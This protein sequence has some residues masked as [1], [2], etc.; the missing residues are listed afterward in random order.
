MNVSKLKKTSGFTLI[1]VLVGAGLL[2][3]MVAFI[4]YLLISSLRAQ[5]FERSVRT[6]TVA[7][8]EAMNRMA[9][10]LRL[11]VALPAVG[12]TGV[13][14]M[15]ANTLPSGVLLP[16]S[17]GTDVGT[18]YTNNGGEYAV[19]KTKGTNGKCS[20]ANHLIFTR[21]K[22]GISMSNAT[23][24][25]YQF[26]PSQ[27]S[28]YVYVEWMVPQSTPDRLWR[29]VYTIKDGAT[30]NDIG[31]SA[32]TQD[33]INIG[34]GRSVQGVIW[35][36][37]T[38]FFTTEHIFYPAGSKQNDESN[39]LVCALNSETDSSHFSNGELKDKSRGE[40]FVR[41]KATMEF[42]VSH[43]IILNSYG[44]DIDSLYYT[45]YNRN[46]F[47]IAFKTTV[48]KGKD[49]GIAGGATEIKFETQV[50]LQAGT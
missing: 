27:L 35:V 5:E 26:N 29:R 40:T 48:H 25:S 4:A 16:D 7:T 21:P 38:A 28:N 42:T 9:D 36:L 11:A 41:S 33:G 6:A 49:S 43:P 47:N 23:Q 44:G 20:I 22:L 8:R 3:V 45:T 32:R 14:F 46:L 17:Y 15:G 34:L 24:S 31:H 30:G 1:E 2:A 50:R 39:W 13:S 10:E 19:T 37:N 18:V 12:A